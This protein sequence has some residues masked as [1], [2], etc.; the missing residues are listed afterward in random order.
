[1][2]YINKKSD[3]GNIPPSLYG[4]KMYRILASF[5]LQQVFILNILNIITCWLCLTY[6]FGCQKVA[7]AVA[8][9]QQ[10]VESRISKNLTSYLSL[11]LVI[12]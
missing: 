6:N 10:P 7:I 4:K 8:L 1:V 2:F 11:S 9:L 5:I 12:G 3:D